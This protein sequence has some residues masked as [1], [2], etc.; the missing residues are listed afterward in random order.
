MNEA[1][2]FEIDVDEEQC[3]RTERR[4]AL[5]RE[6]QTLGVH[7]VEASGVLI[8]EEEAAENLVAI[9]T[10][11]PASSSLIELAPKNT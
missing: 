7:V 11:L 4:N 3:I 10:R 5:A 2:D 8:L 6:L 1:D 9:L